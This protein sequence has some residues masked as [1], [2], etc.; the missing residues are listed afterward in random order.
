M[1]HSY[2]TATSRRCSLARAEGRHADEPPR[3]DPAAEWQSYPTWRALSAQ[4]GDRIELTH[5]RTLATI[6]HHLFPDEI[7][8]MARGENWSLSLAIQWFHRHWWF[9]WQVIRFM[10]L[11]TP[12]SRGFGSATHKAII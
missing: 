2:R 8:E 6:F 9:L 4:F 5:L 1:R 10:T 11:T 7:P 3:F 12:H